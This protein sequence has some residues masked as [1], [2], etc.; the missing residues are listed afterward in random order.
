M[1]PHRHL[2][3]GIGAGG[4]PQNQVEAILGVESQAADLGALHLHGP[5]DVASLLAVAVEAQGDEVGGGQVDG[6][7]LEDDGGLGGIAA[8]EGGR[9]RLGGAKGV[10]DAPLQGAKLGLG[11]IFLGNVLADGDVDDAAGGDVGREQDGRELD[12]RASED[13]SSANARWKRDR[14]GHTAKGVSTGKHT[15]RLS[16]VRRTVTPAST[17]P[18]VRETSMVN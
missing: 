3:A 11:G 18:T 6:V 2:V 14:R 13:V 1:R 9:D 8:A 16:G 17:L 5:G 15:R 7:P 4:R 10:V 12:L